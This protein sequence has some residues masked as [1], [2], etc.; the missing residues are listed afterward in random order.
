MDRN[1]KFGA[2]REAGASGLCKCAE[3]RGSWP[4]RRRFRNAAARS[5]RLCGGPQPRRS[6]PRSPAPRDAPL[7]V[8]CP[9]GC[10]HCAHLLHRIGL[11]CPHPRVTRKTSLP[12]CQKPKSVSRRSH[13]RPPRLL[14]KFSRSKH[15]LA[16]YSSLQASN[17]RIWRD[18]PAL[19]HGT[20][21]ARLYC[22]LCA[23]AA[24]CAPHRERDARLSPW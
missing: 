10:R 6:A 5:W 19:A 7:P 2:G 14:C 17:Q 3:T 22:A 21:P 1:V 9:S 16:A 18:S 23:R 24:H 13:E 15:N 20:T 4:R 8:R 11:H 12:A